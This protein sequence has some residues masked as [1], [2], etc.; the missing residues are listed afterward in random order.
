MPAFNQAA[1]TYRDAASVQQTVAED[2]LHHIRDLHPSSILELGGGTGF[3][4]ELLATTF[5]NTPITVIDNAPATIQVAK[6]TI[7]APNIHWLC[8]DIE[9][10]SLP[11]ADLIASNM[12]LQWVPS[13]KWIATCHDHL[14]P[15]G[16]LAISLAG[17]GTFR[18]LQSAVQQAYPH[19]PRL[20][21]A[22]FL[23][24]DAL[25]QALSA[26]FTIAHVKTDTHALYFPDVFH[27]LRH[28]KA[29]GA[30][31]ANTLKHGLFTPQHL[32]KITQYYPKVS[33][34]IALE[35][36]VIVIIAKPN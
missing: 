16:T 12:T 29:T 21:S 19:F 36:E 33:T 10:I 27:A 24:V 32:R 18:S 26:Q 35:Y 28:I 7:N 5:P 3:L 6:H 9:T 34:Q 30:Y 13:N 31:H 23:N 2:L 8:H 14:S 20:P 4:S 25:S 11:K 22:S 1:D 17:P 15:D